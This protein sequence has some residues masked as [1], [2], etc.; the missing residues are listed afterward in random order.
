[1]PDTL[2]LQSHKDPLPNEWLLTCIGSVERWCE[3]H[4]F[5]YHFM[6]D[7]LFDYV[8]TSLLEKTGPQR[9]VATDLARIR[10]IQSYM[11]EGFER[12]I[13]CDADFLIFDPA[14]FI[15]P[16]ESYALGREVWI[17]A[18]RSNPAK[19]KAHIK[20]HNAFLMFCSGNS[21]LN[22]YIET[23]ERLLMKNHGP[24]PPQFIGP[25][26]LTAI[27]NVAQCPVLETAAMLSPLVLRDIA[28]GSGAALELF[29]L[30]SP[31]PAAAA[32]LCCSLFERGE[33]A[34]ETLDACINRLMEDRH[35]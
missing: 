26:L 20:V 25:K 10:A 28:V 9:I 3:L 1:M 4:N 21:F 17:Q 15:L 14:G 5:Q 19:L 24:M 8:P 22:F 31:E 29:R 35:V 33:I 27:H 34:T 13:W 23:A 7:D 32:N 18:D 30:R 16:D 11:N 2:V 12:V 6:H